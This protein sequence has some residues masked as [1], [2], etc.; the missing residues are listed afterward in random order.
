MAGF[1]EELMPRERAIASTAEALSFPWPV[2]TRKLTP[3]GGETGRLMKTLRAAEDYPP[4]SRST[5][6]GYAVRSADTFGAG[7]GAPAFLRVAGEVPMGGMP[8]F[9]LRSGECAVIHTGGILPEGA[10]GVLMAEDADSAGNWIEARASLQRGENILRAGE[11]F[12]KDS[13]LLPGGAKIDWRTFGLLA[14]AGETAP[15]SPRPGIVILSTGD[16]IVP[17]E[18]VNLSPGKFRDVNSLLLSSLLRKE[19]YESIFAGIVPD[20]PEPMEKAL[21]AALALGDVVILSGGSSV[22]VRDHCSALLASLPSPGLLVRGILMAPGKPTLI[23]GMKEEKKLVIGLPG[24]PF[25]CFVTAWTVLLPLLS[26]LIWGEVMEPWKKI[27][28]PLD[29]PLYGHTG[30]E[31]FIPCAFSGGKVRPLP[32]Q[33]SF[34]KALFEAEGLFRLPPS[35]ETLRKGEEAE[36]WLW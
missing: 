22:S 12:S 1:V 25:S 13:V 5:R 35:S 6:D 16:E 14:M 11:E 19:G 2:K 33:S 23:A 27:F 28:L 34:S 29:A 36:I 17:P 15:E 4:Y 30:L 24:H 21:S 32:I 3:G 8:D 18:T 7:S 9:A 10:D 26:A 31:E 20:A